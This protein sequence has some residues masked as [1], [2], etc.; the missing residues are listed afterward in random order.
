LSA[1]HSRLFTVNDVDDA[2]GRALKRNIK[3]QPAGKEYNRTQT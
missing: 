3:S 1:R 2:G